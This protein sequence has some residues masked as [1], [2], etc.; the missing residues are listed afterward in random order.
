VSTWTLS[1]IVAG[2]ACAGA[3]LVT[4]LAR[5]KERDPNIARVLFMLYFSAFNSLNVYGG[6]SVEFPQDF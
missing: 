1:A 6:D 4:K 5:T 2:A 3:E